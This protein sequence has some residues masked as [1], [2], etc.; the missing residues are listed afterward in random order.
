M[1]VIGFYWIFSLAGRFAFCQTFMMAL[2]GYTCAWV[3]GSSVR[4]PWFVGILAAMFVAACLACVVG[5]CLVKAPQLSFAIGTLAVTG[6][7][8]V[9]FT[10]WTAF[11][12]AGGTVV[13]VEPPSLF[14]YVFSSDWQIFWLF[15]AVVTILLVVGAF[16]ERSPVRR[17]A[18]SARDNR[19]ISVLSGVRTARVQLALF[20][21]GSV[22]GG[23]S[24]ALMGSWQGVVANSSYGV[25][26]AIGIFLML[27]LGGQGSIWGA[28]I[29]AAFYVIIPQLLVRF[30]NLEPV[31]YGSVLLIV[32]ILMPQGLT[33]IMAKLVSLH[34][35]LR[36]PKR[37]SEVE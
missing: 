18:I 26:L 21:L 7:G 33:G 23:L 14:G 19:L 24:G 16:I 32:M 13:G 29:G 2:G 9:V 25:S 10:N 4:M 30:D 28:V 1:T 15:L 20:M 12:G 8:T 35:A 27:I 34:R 17:E 22:V 37:A 5:L 11:T 31:I 36:L 3:T 6:I